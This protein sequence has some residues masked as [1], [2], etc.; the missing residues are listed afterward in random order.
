M[1]KEYLRRT[2][3]AQYLQ[4]R[5][6]AYTVETLAKLACV[7]GGPVMRRLGRFPVYTIADLDAWLAS[8]LSPPG[9]STAELDQQRAA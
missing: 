5:A 3:A 1:G 7:G 4:E 2:E 9:A 8:K 6:G